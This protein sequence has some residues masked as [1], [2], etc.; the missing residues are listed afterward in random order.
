[1]PG[2]A[3]AEQMM[4]TRGVALSVLH[5]THVMIWSLAGGVLLLV[6]RQRH[7]SERNLAFD[8]NDADQPTSRS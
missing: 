8:S 3:D 1:L 5:R 6:D 4:R 2:I 7:P